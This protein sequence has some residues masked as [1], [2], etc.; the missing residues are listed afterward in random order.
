M[1][2]LHEHLGGES[3]FQAAVDR[4]YR[5]ILADPRVADY[6]DA[7]DMDA[8]V[9]KQRAFLTYVTGGSA[10]YS[11]RDMRT[12]HASLVERGLVDSAVDVVFGHLEATLLEMGATPADVAEVVALAER[13][14]DEVLGR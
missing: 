2:S 6:F 7:I 8:Q 5:R 1:Q 9:T 3:A 4:L 14:R 12:V 13:V 10:Q 11:G